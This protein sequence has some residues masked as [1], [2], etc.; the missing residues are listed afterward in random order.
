M[1]QCSEE[2]INLVKTIQAS[3]SD[4]RAAQFYESLIVLVKIKYINDEQLYLRFFDKN[5]AAIKANLS[6]ESITRD[7]V[8]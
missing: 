7:Q 8:Q 2:Y 3:Y 1:P 5:I 6:G 4:A